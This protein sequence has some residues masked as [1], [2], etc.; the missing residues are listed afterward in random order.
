M[1]DCTAV[2]SQPRRTLFTKG[3]SPAIE[4]SSG[5]RS[6]Q[7]V[8]Q[9]GSSLAYTTVCIK[10]SSD[11]RAIRKHP[12]SLIHPRCLSSTTKPRLHVLPSRNRACQRV[13]PRAP[14]N[15]CGV[16]RASLLPMGSKS[17]GPEGL[18]TLRGRR[19]STRTTLT[20]A[21]GKEHAGVASSSPQ[22]G[23]EREGEAK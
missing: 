10:A 14:S 7:E 4:R 1:R 11:T 20:A 5:M 3:L 12:S 2:S 16:Y 17:D 6:R 9:L 15:V 8:K 19:G 18:E 21:R 13:V 23:G 22:K